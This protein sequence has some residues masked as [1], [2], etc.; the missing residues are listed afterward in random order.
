[1]LI[2]L[3]SCASV[4]ACDK[5]PSPTL[6]DPGSAVTAQMVK[7]KNDMKAYIKAADDYL[8]CVELDASRYNKMVDEMQASAD[9][10]NSIVRKYRKRMGTA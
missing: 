1:M 9:E 6:P 4:F 2:A 7:A 10:F 3:T 8:A 5:P